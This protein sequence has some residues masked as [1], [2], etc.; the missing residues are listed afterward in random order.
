MDFFLDSGAYSAWTRGVK[1]NIDEYIEFIK[2]H[3]DCISV[4]ATLDDLEDPEIS[5][6]NWQYMRSKG[7][8]PLPVF[9]AHAPIEYLLAYMKETDYIAIGALA[10]TTTNTRLKHLDRIWGGYL[11]DKSGYPI[12]KV[13]GFGITTLTIVSRYPW[14]SVDSTSWLLM[15]AYGK[16]YVPRY[17][18]GAWVYNLTPMAIGISNI[19]SAIGDEEGGHFDTL[20]GREQQL[21]VQYL[22]E[23]GYVI[24]KSE[25]REELESYILLED[26]RWSGRKY[27]NSFREVETVI[28]H[29]VCNSYGQR[30]EINA[31]FFKEFADIFPRWDMIQF[32]AAYRRLG[33]LG[34]GV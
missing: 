29:G 14:Y 25:F 17:I 23:K 15:A 13:H 12:I 10:K 22:Q 6:N 20:S 9:H 24:G 5:Y 8:N 30:S 21:V 11:T 4:Y 31:L 7:L 32:K 2:A 19:S 33:L 34:R 27:S 28:E 1:I 18:G 26:E 16:I 3:S